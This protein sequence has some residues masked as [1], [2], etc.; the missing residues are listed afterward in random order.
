MYCLRSNLNK[1]PSTELCCLPARSHGTGIPRN[2][3]DLV[4]GDQEV[5]LELLRN[6]K[7]LQAASL[8]RF[9]L[10]SILLFAAA[11]RIWGLDQN[12]FADIYYAAAVR[13]MTLSLHNFLYLSFDP[14]GFVSVDKPPLALWIQV[15]S[16]KLFGFSPLSLLLPQAFEGIASVALIYHLVRRRFDAWAGVFTAMAV[17]ITPICVAV[18]RFNDVNGCLLLLLLLAAW[19]FSIAAERARRTHL[20]LGVLFAGLAFNAK[21]LAA[22]VVLPAFYLA[23]LLGAQLSLTRRLLDLSVASI[24]LFAISFSW[25]VF[26][27]LT[28][29]E[30]RP[31]A[32]STTD[33]SM[34]SLT[35]GW[36]GFQRFS[37]RSEEPKPPQDA[38]VKN[39][40]SSQRRDAV[41]AGTGAPGPFRLLE[42]ANAAQAAWMLPLILVAIGFFAWNR[43]WRFPLSF[44]EQALLLW[45]GW[46]FMYLVVLSFL[47]GMMHLYY[48]VMLA[49]PF[50]ALTGIGARSLWLAFR[51]GDGRWNAS[52]FPLALLLTAVWQTY[53]LLYSPSAGAF[54]IAIL[55]FGIAISAFGFFKC[56]SLREP[57]LRA[58][59][60]QA[61]FTAGGLASLLAA[62]LFWSLTP[63]LAVNKGRFPPEANASLLTEESRHLEKQKESYKKLTAFL[64]GNHRDERYLLAARHALQLAPVIAETGVPAIAFGGFMGHDP[65]LTVDAFAKMAADN[66]I[67]YVLLQRRGGQDSGSDY[68]PNAEIVKWVREHGTPVAASKWRLTD[69]GDGVLSDT[70]LYD[71]HVLPASDGSKPL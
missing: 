56:W 10:G 1:I 43:R 20:L 59:R 62:P 46:F 24:V 70:E 16:A 51:N 3:S 57:D 68:G 31:F 33:N 12:D 32:G 54:L 36:N 39:P 7:Y 38:A 60:W 5:R 53:V 71:L 64:I 30:K 8:E 17:A 35:L 41:R 49:P 28:P 58:W 11:L 9:A 69:P 61:V 15:A 63:L 55:W 6:A 25:I 42:P 19:A 26:F 40:H 45:V 4:D 37:I 14:A 50:A 21:M 66:Q 22:F 23:Y 65:I 2:A 27:D 52:L 34:M 47:R 29:P 67:R 13:S 48:W 18:D 44:E